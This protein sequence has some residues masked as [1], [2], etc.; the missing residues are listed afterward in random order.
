MFSIRK[1]IKPVFQTIQLQHCHYAM[2]CSEKRFVNLP[3]DLFNIGR[4]SPM[5]EKQLQTLFGV[6]AASESRFCSLI[7]K[8]I[9]GTSCA[10]K[11]LWELYFLKA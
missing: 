4:S 5:I 6:K 1:S 3:G 2:D 8:D 10:K 11:L 9:A 7:L